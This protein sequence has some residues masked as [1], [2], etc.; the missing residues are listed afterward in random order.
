MS[1]IKRAKSVVN[2]VVNKIRTFYKNKNN[3]I[4]IDLGTANTLIC[5]KDKGIVLN[6]ASSVSY[7]IEDGEQIGHLY[8]NQAKEL[9][10]KTPFKIEVANPIEDGVVNRSILSEN[11]V[12]QFMSNVYKQNSLLQ[13]IVIVGVP[14]SASEVEKKALQEIIEKC[15]AKECLLIYESIASAVGAGIDIH[16]PSGSLVIDIGGGTTELSVISLGGIIK[17]RSFKY[18]GRKIDKSII[19]FLAKRYHLLIG[20]NTAENIKKQ[21]GSVFITDEENIKSITITGRNLDTNTPQ[22]FTINQKDIVMATAEFT[23][24]LIDNLKELLEITSPELMKDISRN[25]IYVCGGVANLQSIDYII[26]T[27]TGLKVNIPEQPEL[28][29]IRGLNTIVQNY[30]QYENILFKQV[31]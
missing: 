10:G 6:E 24:M 17:N 29:L 4:G 14:F 3:V 25:G 22:D 15:N 18:G 27:I 28:C 21:I 13:P 2:I 9:L 1:F 12:R 19:D 30:K 11:M 7:V 31:Q 16:K 23:N 26:E 20:E 5:I 8:G